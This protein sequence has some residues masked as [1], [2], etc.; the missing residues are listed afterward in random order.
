MDLELGRYRLTGRIASGGMADVY[1]AKLVGVE[2]FEKE[3]A[4][5]KILP[6]W[7]GN[8]EFVSML[9]DEA[10]VLLHLNHSNIVQVHELNREGDIYYLVMEYVRG[11]DLRALVN[12]SLAQ[13]VKPG[14]ALIYYIIGQVCAGLQYA[15][16][17]LGADHRPLQIVHRD[18]SPQN[19]LLSF[20]GE[21]KITDFG[22]A[23]AVG[24]STETVTGTLKGKF[25]YMSPEQ[26]LGQKVDQ[27]T[28]V[29]AVGI[30]LYE[31]A[32]G[33]RC[34]KGDNDL[35]TLEAVKNS[36]IAFPAD[37]PGGLKRVVEKALTK[38]KA[39]RT[40]SIAD[41][42]RELRQLELGLPESA[43]ASD[44]KRYLSELFPERVHGQADLPA[45]APSERRTKIL[46][47][48]KPEE[49]PRTLLQDATLISQNLKTP[50]APSVPVNPAGSTTA[51]R[52]WI[53]YPAALVLLV[54]LAGLGWF[55]LNQPKEEAPVA[56]PVALPPPVA[57]TPS[58]VEAPTQIEAAV[59]VPQ[60]K[61][62]EVTPEQ[63]PE[64]K[65]IRFG[66]LNVAAKPW[67]RVSISNVASG[68]ETP[69]SRNKIPEGDHVLKVAFPPDN[70]VVSKTIRISANATL[71]CQINFEGSSQL[72]CR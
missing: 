50:S 7:S 2:G 12:R 11:V 68:A 17:K 21:V 26:A 24:K 40:A 57:P 42:R 3:V 60:P 64:T 1:R 10:K 6:Y 32:T 41:L 43:G 45:E 72:N 23:K 62:A 53:L 71:R 39:D 35:E 47:K 33:Q 36:S 34:F 9:I 37:F 8:P 38:D 44:L 65:P 19:V 54:T 63:I 28:D 29:F 13:G 61:A 67:G 49:D 18:V 14:V 22:I 59:P 16:E 30:L 31:L 52:K 15:H 46:L 27:R 69:F 5:K 48:E 70:R 56:Q 4:V 25:S 55:S 58:S 51:S 66:S 20:E